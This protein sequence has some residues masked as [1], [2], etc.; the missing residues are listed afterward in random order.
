M[1]ALALNAVTDRQPTFRAG[2]DRGV[3]AETGLH[4]FGGLLDA[5]RLSAGSRRARTV[6]EGEV[7][8]AGL[9]IVTNAVLQPFAGDQKNRSYTLIAR[10]EPKE[11][12]GAGDVPGRTFAHGDH[13]EDRAFG[14]VGQQ[15]AAASLA[16]RP[17]SER[18]GEFGFSGRA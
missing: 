13:F 14:G 7:E 1:A 3:A 2:G 4:G 10:S 5:K 18:F 16:D 12:S 17:I 9:G 11:D 15:I 6:A 8:A